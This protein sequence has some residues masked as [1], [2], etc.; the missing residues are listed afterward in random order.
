MSYN[1]PTC[2][3]PPL[4]WGGGGG[5]GVYGVLYFKYGQKMASPQ[6]VP[7]ENLVKIHQAVLELCTK[8]YLTGYPP[9]NFEGG[10]YTEYDT[11]HMAQ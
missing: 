11:F 2:T 4:D 9:L 5:G 3:P 1:V 8:V 7:T 10:G 6:V